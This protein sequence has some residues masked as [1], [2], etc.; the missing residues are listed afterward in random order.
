MNSQ[1]LTG[2]QVVERFKFGDDN[3]GMPKFYK[4]D[5]PK[6]FENVY[7]F[8]GK[9]Y[10][11][12][13]GNPVWRV[14]IGRILQF[15]APEK[16]MVRVRKQNSGSFIRDIDF[17]RNHNI[18]L[19]FNEKSA[20]SVGLQN[21]NLFPTQVI[22]ETLEYNSTRNEF[23]QYD[24]RRLLLSHYTYVPVTEFYRKKIFEQH[25]HINYFNFIYLYTSS[26]ERD[27]LKLFF[28][29]DAF[30]E[31]DDRSYLYSETRRS[32]LQNNKIMSGDEVVQ[33]LKVG[34]DEE[35]DFYDFNTFFDNSYIFRKKFGP[36][37]D[38]N[39]EPLWRVFIGKIL[40][41]LAPQT[42]MVRVLKERDGTFTRD[43]GYR[44][45]N[46]LNL[47][48]KNKSK[49]TV[50]V[51]DRLIPTQALIELF[52]YN[53]TSD[54]YRRE[55]YLRRILLSD[56]E[57]RPFTV[58][59]EEKIFK[60]HESFNVYEED[61]FVTSTPQ[62]LYDLFIAEEAGLVQASRFLTA[63]YPKGPQLQITNLPI[64]AKFLGQNK[65]GDQLYNEEAPKPGSSRQGTLLQQRSQTG[66]VIEPDKQGERDRQLQRTLL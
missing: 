7:C 42:F 60:R 61:K 47:F 65:L 43:T 20:D 11:D 35:E 25:K 64:I 41:F 46:N 30:I 37:K 29:K 62:I 57:F 17:I 23:V 56:Y 44:R 40:Q 38:L 16:Y 50:G 15:L 58:F 13:Y 39:S 59:Y 1:I 66:Y 5:D 45:Q 55:G 21:S 12:L 36:F 8:R 9:Y 3:E 10:S 19:Y 28:E 63:S 53:S 49:D 4:F 22:V 34:D 18:H 6:T 48:L 31:E 14:F 24:L 26:D 54:E 51:R 2:D 32:V 52:E 27:L 33:R